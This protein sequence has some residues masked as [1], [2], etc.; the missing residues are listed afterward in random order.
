MDSFSSHSDAVDAPARNCFAIE[1]SD[2]V[3]LVSITK[4]I[5]VGNSGDV[6]LKSVDAVNNVNFASV[7][8][9]TILPVRAEFVRAAGTT[10]TGLVGLA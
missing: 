9:G 1:P 2:T 3:P 8:A 10:A 4:A 5:Y 7:P 6:A